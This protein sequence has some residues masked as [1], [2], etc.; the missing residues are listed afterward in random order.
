MTTEDFWRRRVVPSGVDRDEAMELLPDGYAT[1]LRLRDGG[2]S[3]AE[4]AAELGVDEE[5]VDTLLQ[6][7]DGKLRR[8]LEAD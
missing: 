1:A 2:R 5:V 3:A 7:G 6:I 4:I 8:I